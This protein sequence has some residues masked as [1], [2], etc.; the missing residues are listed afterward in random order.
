MGNHWRVGS[1]CP[2]YCFLE[3]LACAN[4]DGIGYKNHCDCYL[5]CVFGDFIRYLIGG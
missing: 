2:P 1:Y 3:G 4:F 5:D